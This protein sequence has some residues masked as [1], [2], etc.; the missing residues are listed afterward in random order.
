[1]VESGE[2]QEGMPTHKNMLFSCFGGLSNTGLTSALACLEVVKE[3]G[4]EKVAIGCLPSVPLCVKPVLS[5]A[6]AAKKIITVDG[7]PFECA[8]KTIEAAGFKIA[9]SVVLTRDIGM[10][11]MALHTDI[12][13]GLG[14]EKYISQEDIK[15]AKE[16]IIKAIME[17]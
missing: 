5:K 9:K 6:K 15:K 17:K 1:M 12:G 2:W 14:V 3:L 8:R 10:K 11:K 4:L 13:K 16:L 7:C